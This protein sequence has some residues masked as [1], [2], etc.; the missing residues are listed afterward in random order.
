MGIKGT[1]DPVSAGNEVL[2]VDWN[3]TIAASQNGAQH[4][5]G[6]NITAP[7]AV[8]LDTFDNDDNKV[9]LT[10][11]ADREEVLNYKGFAVEDGSTDDE[12]FIQ[13][14]GYISG[15]SGLVAGEKY[16][17]ADVGSA[18]SSIQRNSAVADNEDVGNVGGTEHRRAHRFTI[19][20][21][22]KLSELNVRLR[23]SGSPA[24]NFVAE[25][26]QGT[27]SGASDDGGGIYTGYQGTVAAASVTGSY[28]QYT[29]FSGEGIT[30]PAGTYYILFYHDTLSNNNIFQ[31][32]S[33]TTGN[34]S[35][36]YAWPST[37]WAGNSGDHWIEINFEADTFTAGEITDYFYTYKRYVG[38]ALSAT[39]L[40]AEKKANLGN[41]ESRS[42]SSVY[43]ADSDGFLSLLIDSAS[44]D[45]DVYVNG[46]L[47]ASMGTSSE[48]DYILVPIRKG[49]FYSFVKNSGSNP[50][51]RFIDMY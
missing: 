29:M 19:A 28:A 3:D 49:D 14:E 41:R 8:F 50:T 9:Y 38:Y 5:L 12:K 25:I 26:W 23:T 15:F 16:F 10:D 35:N 34:H 51:I 45:T 11:A 32:D 47:V 20:A 43:R 6:E 18:P 46:S 1:N 24:G 30:L 40:M 31:M 42:I 17:L 13:D 33:D 2:A 36:D 44:T 48:S 7:L 21:P 39:E 4:T 37:T 22:I 27:P